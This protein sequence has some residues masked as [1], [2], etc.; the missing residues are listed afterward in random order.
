MLTCVLRSLFSSSSMVHLCLKSLT[1]CC[2]ALTSV[3][4]M[5]TAPMFSFRNLGQVKSKDLRPILKALFKVT[6]CKQLNSW[7]CVRKD[8]P[9]DCWAGLDVH[10]EPQE[11]KKIIFKNEQLSSPNPEM[12]WTRLVKENKLNS[13]TYHLWDCQQRQP[14]PGISETV[15]FLSLEPNKMTFHI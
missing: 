5:P 14:S 1:S 10:T 7:S 3:E 15:P 12:S 8:T 9:V 6:N 2:S 13:K 11:L 4:A